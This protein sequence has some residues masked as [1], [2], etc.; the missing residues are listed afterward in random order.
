M[1]DHDT[2][3]DDLVVATDLYR[4]GVRIAAT[5]DLFAKAAYQEAAL[6]LHRVASH[7]AH[8]W[9]ITIVQTSDPEPYPNAAIMAK[10]VRE[11]HRL[12]VSRDFSNDLDYWSVE[13]NV[14]FRVV[15][16]LLG[17]IGDVDNTAPVYSFDRYGEHAANARQL[18]WHLD[19][20]DQF[21]LSPEAMS[22]LGAESVGQ[23][24]YSITEDAFVNDPD[25][26]GRQ[27]ACLFPLDFLYTHLDLQD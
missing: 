3:H 19:H 12:L 18:Q 22:V 11:S 25:H 6:L 21:P 10:D 15:H 27:P 1:T 14:A 24:A 20:D 23:N 13:D 17:H 5:S 9:D 16:D 26:Y 7:L 8:A 2:L 4:Q